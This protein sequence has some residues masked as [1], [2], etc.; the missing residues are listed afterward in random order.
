MDIWKKHALVSLENDLK[1]NL[2]MTDLVGRL[3]RPAGGFMT[4]LER[5]HVEEV[6]GG[7]ERVGRIIGILRG[8]GNK[9]F[10]TF[11]KILK[12]SGNEVWA[13]KIEASVHQ[14]EEYHRANGTESSTSACLMCLVSLGL[15]QCY[16]SLS[17]SCAQCSSGL[18]GELH[19]TGHRVV[20]TGNLHLGCTM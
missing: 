18:Q 6:Q 3:E 9:E 11:L 13:D 8:K 20:I 17:S 12:E 19:D 1:V 14:F 7:S 4:E 2:G 10:D 15:D 16:V 5:K